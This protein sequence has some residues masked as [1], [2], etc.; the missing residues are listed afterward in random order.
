LVNIPEQAIG[1]EVVTLQVIESRIGKVT[2]TG[3]RYFTTAKILA[4]LPSFVPGAILYIPRIRTELARVNKNPD[5]KVSPTIV[6]GKEVGVIDVELKVEDHLPLHGSL[7]LNNRASPDTT[8]LRLS[9]ALRY[10]NLWQKEHSLSIQYQVSPED[11]QE[12]S[13]Y[14]GSYSLPLPWNRDQRF[15]LYG[16]HS[17]SNTLTKEFNVA[18]KGDIVGGR[19]LLPLEGVDGYSHNLTLGVD[20]KKFNDILGF[21]TGGSSGTET[22]VR[23]LP[24]SVSYGGVLSD[25]SGT[26]QFNAAVNFAFRGLVTD[27]QEFQEKRFQGSANYLYLTLGCER[28]QRLPGGMGLYL[29]LDGQASDQPLITNEQYAAGGMESVRGYRESE[30]SG[31]NAIHGTLEV[32]KQNLAQTFGLGDRFLVTPYIFSDFAALEVKNPLPGQDRNFLLAGFGAGVRGFLFRSLE[33]QI[34]WGFPLEDTAKTDTGESRLY[35]KVK[36]LF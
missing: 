15:I 27:Q 35:F 33:Y 8:E 29:K 5:I 25:A 18:G 21:S 28:T 22:P 26:T 36:Y 13:V 1:G 19:Y 24:F 31:D 11:T 32:S 6:P 3:N 12:V 20:Y 2:V 14:S 23:Y 10:D 4:D 16:V 9:A 30:V 34:D 17:D 7:E